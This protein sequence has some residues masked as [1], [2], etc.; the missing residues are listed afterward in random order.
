MDTAVVLPDASA[1]ND[2]KRW[3]LV[4]HWHRSMPNALLQEICVTRLITS[5]SPASGTSTNWVEST[6]KSHDRRDFDLVR[7]PLTSLSDDGLVL[8]ASSFQ[9]SEGQ[10]RC[11]SRACSSQTLVV[12][13]GG[14]P[15][16]MG[17]VA[18]AFRCWCRRLV[19]R[20][21]HLWW[22]GEWVSGMWWCGVVPT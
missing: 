22:C 19:A 5:T 8:S 18:L 7:A 13:S 15:L 17:V 1:S 21:L 6:V 10:S 2:V 16:R 12:G 9:T 11:S 4:R 3:L 20:S 14:G